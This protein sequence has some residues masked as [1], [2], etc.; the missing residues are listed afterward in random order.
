MALRDDATVTAVLTHTADEAAR[1]RARAGVAY[2][3]AAY[4]LW[5]LFP[6]YFKLVAHVWPLEVVTHRIVWGVLFLLALVWVT[7]RRHALLS[8]L[9]SRRTILTLCAT[10]TLIA[11]NWLVF[12]YAVA[13]DQVM[14]ASLGYFVNPLINVLLGFVFLR[15]RLRPWQT[16]SV[17]LAFAGVTYLT[18]GSGTF[19]T[20]AMLMAWSFGFYGLLRKI[21]N[22]DAILGLTIETALIAPLATAYL[23]WEVVAGRATFANESLPMS[24]LLMLAGPLT[25]LPLMWFA[26]AARRLRL[27]TLGFIQYLAPTGHFLLAVLAYGEPFTHVHLVAFGCIW[28]ALAIYTVDSATRARVPQPPLR[29]TA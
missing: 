20:L 18:V 26:A 14:Q 3:L 4:G 29:P 10:T 28:V 7:G 19:P 23:A 1:R 15:E 27:T 22:V 5:G 13:T 17:L 16:V 24:L 21:A 11:G 8:V 25:A 12:V 9:R 6:A 2:A